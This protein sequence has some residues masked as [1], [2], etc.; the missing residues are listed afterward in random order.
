MI[1]HEKRMP[2]ELVVVKHGGSTMKNSEDRILPQIADLQKV[3]MDVVVVHGGGNRI[4]ELSNALGIPTRFVDGRRFTCQR[5][6]EAAV[7]TLAGIVN[8][9]LVAGL[10]QAGVVAVGL[11]GVDGRILQTELAGEAFGAVGNVTAVNTVPIEILLGA[12]ILPV[13]APIGIN[14]DGEMHNINADLAAAAVAIA[15]QAD[16]LLFV[17]DVSGVRAGSV[18]RQQL[19]VTETKLLIANQEID[20]GMIP[21]A[22]AAMQASASGV[23]HVR[24]IGTSP[25]VIAEGIAG[26]VGTKFV[27]HS[28]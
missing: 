5:T 20:G 10:L 23:A 4:T 3:G 2:K 12:G 17:T 9:E 18:V 1:G 14:Q 11:S 15:L 26:R 22:E 19:S 21:K 28:S 7:M 25:S 8:K 24:I 27:S 13:L 6:L 16:H